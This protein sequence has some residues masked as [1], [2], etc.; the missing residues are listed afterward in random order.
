MESNH[1]ALT[2]PDLPETLI[3]E[4]EEHIATLTLNRPERYNA[5]SPEMRTGIRAA[6]NTANADDE[7]WVIVFRA[8]G[9]KAFCAGADLGS[10]VKNLTA[11][12]ETQLREVVPDPAKRHFHDV[13]KPIIAAINGICTAGGLEMMQGTDIRIA[14]ENARFGLGEVRWGIVPLGGSHVRLPRQIPWAVAMELLLT[15]DMI[16]AERAREI[17]LVNQ[18][19]PLAE[20]HETAWNLAKRLTKNG[21]LAL[22]TAKESAVRSMFLEPAFVNDF[23]LAQR[24]FFS[25]DAK[26][27]PLAFKEKR[28]PK[29]TGH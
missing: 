19:V 3:Y 24:V 17:G 22:R 14:S 25:D 16:P 4:V 29:F 15:G 5:I 26:E 1:M 6:F 27:G 20:L 11:T 13:F 10:T 7:V 21:P 9:E 8:V 18:V 12:P 23:Y 2:P 28:E